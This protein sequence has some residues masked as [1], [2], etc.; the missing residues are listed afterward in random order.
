MI[1]TPRRKGFGKERGILK[2]RTLKRVG[3]VGACS[4]KP[5]IIF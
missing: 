5:Y 4:R 3:V 1:R 2:H